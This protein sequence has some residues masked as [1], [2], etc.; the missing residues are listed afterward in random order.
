MVMKP[1]FN[2][3]ALC[4]GTYGIATLIHQGPNT[5]AYSAAHRITGQSAIVTC[6]RFLHVAGDPPSVETFK[7]TAEKLAA[8]AIDDIPRIYGYGVHDGVYWIA[9]QFLDEPTIIEMHAD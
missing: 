2:T 8:L 3:G 6:S 4:G 7:A 5:E 9:S 1:I